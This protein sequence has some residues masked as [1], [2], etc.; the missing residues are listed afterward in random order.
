MNP[1]SP[2]RLVTHN[3]SA[4]A[5]EVVATALVLALDDRVE[6]IERKP[7]PGGDELA[8]PE[9]YVLDFGRRHEPAYRNF[10]HHQ[11]GADEPPRCTITLILEHAGLLAQARTFW[12]GLPRA[13]LYDVRGPDAVAR[14]YG[15]PG[16]NVVEVFQSPVEEAVRSAFSQ[17]HVLRRGDALFAALALIG[18][19]L[20]E[21]LQ[22][23]ASTLVWLRAQAA[24][25]SLVPGV[26][27]LWFTE[28]P[29]AGPEVYNHAFEVFRAGLE[30]EVRLVV[31][32]DSRGEGWQ[33]RRLSG[34]DGADFRRLAGSDR[35][36]FIHV[37]GF[38]A[39]THT[40]EPREQ[41]EDLIRGALVV[42]GD[43]RP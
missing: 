13:E 32:P 31:V 28:R 14:A 19:S 37:S 41:V 33:M 6:R 34:W 23:C 40:R 11:F 1:S 36:R 20:V 18:K 8:D 30:P 5:D 35:L 7:E 16:G 10:D 42:A 17:V 12:P 27:V 15:L 43:G 3:G 4:H 25:R 2:R 39:T 9:C 26:K 38:L 24:T 29:E 22:A 21:D